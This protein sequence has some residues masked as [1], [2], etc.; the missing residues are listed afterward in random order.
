MRR[1]I[2]LKA[3]IVSILFVISILS[4]ILLSFNAM[5]FN[6][7]GFTFLIANITFASNSFI[8]LYERYE[9]ISK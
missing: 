1:K 7:I 3:I 2:N 6:W 4:I 8:Y 9:R 5:C